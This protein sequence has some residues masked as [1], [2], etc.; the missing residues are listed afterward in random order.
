[1]PMVSLESADAMLRSLP[2]TVVHMVSPRPLLFVHGEDDDVAKIELARKLYERAGPPKDFVAI[3][4]MDHIG[5]DTGDGR[6]VPA[7]APRGRRTGISMGA[8]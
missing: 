2:T 1:M 4:G 3:P 8:L 5:L 6:T 7:G